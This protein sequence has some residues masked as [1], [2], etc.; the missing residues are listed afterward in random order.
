M[1]KLFFNK[2]CE[3]FWGLCCYISCKENVHQLRQFF[4]H[5]HLFQMNGLKKLWESRRC[6]FKRRMSNCCSEIYNSILVYHPKQ[7]MDF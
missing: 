5:D 4:E 3:E 7:K 6:G 2:V 1:R